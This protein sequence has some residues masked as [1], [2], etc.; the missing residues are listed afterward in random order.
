MT[1]NNVIVTN[2]LIVLS[3]ITAP[4]VWADDSVFFVLNKDDIEEVLFEEHIAWLKLSKSATEGLAEMTNSANQGKWLEVS[5]EDLHVVKAYINTTVKS[6]II[7]VDSPSTDFKRL[8]K[9]IELL[10][11]QK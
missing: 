5:V 6:G 11:R 4:I 1:I 7:K 10:S 9:E 2:I 8:L 3:C